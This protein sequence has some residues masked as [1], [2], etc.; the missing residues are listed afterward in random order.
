VDR[1]IEN[2]RTVVISSLSVIET[3]SAFRRTYNRDELSEGEMNGLLGEFFREALEDV[4]LVPLEESVLQFSFDLI[5]EDDLRTL[6]SLQLSAATSITSA[7]DDVTF[8]C[9]D[10]NLVS[11]ADDRG[12]DTI[13]PGE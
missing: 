12:L 6:D 2:D 4:L 11:V 8:V 5:L 10:R 13:R 9:A 7:A 3:I 1:L